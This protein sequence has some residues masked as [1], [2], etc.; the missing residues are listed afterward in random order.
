ML[1]PDC[2][3]AA[4]LGLPQ[5]PVSPG[6]G[7]NRGWPSGQRGVGLAGALLRVICAGTSK[8]LLF[9]FAIRTELPQTCRLLFRAAIPCTVSSS[10][11]LTVS[12]FQPAFWSSTVLSNSIA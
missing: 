7:P 2:T 3:R 9:V 12:I 8:I 6:G 5:Y 4:A 11:G 10:P 1:T